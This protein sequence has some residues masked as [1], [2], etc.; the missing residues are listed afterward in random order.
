MSL[1]TRYLFY[2]KLYPDRLLFFLRNGEWICYGKEKI[3]WKSFHSFKLLDS[4]P[5]CM[6]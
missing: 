5:I 3:V 6:L 2:K 1:K 4:F